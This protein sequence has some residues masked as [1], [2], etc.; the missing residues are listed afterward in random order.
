MAGENQRTPLIPLLQQAVGNMTGQQRWAGFLAAG[1]RT[2]G[3]FLV[4]W[5]TLTAE[6]RGTWNY[7]GKEPS[8]DLM[9]PVEEVG[10][11]TLDGSTR[12]KVVQQR[13]AMQ[14]QLLTIAL[15]RHPNR[16]ARPVTV[17]PN[18]SDDKCAGSWLLAIPSTD[19][20]L[21]SWVFK[22]ALSSHLCLPSPELRE[23]AT[24]GEGKAGKSA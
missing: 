2:A 4:A 7:L 13:E 9:A 11:R 8:G 16:E 5:D 12:T 3:E 23:G 18:I 1:S 20:S 19:L 22:E 14:H 21:S 17:F 10:G 6:A 15:S 24:V